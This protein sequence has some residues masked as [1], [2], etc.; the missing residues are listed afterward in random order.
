[1]AYLLVITNSTRDD[2]SWSNRVLARFVET[3][4]AEHPG[5]E[6]RERSTLSIP[7]LDL[8]SQR[9]GRVPAS[10][11]TP[12]QAAAFALTNELTAEVENA[13]AVVIATPMYNWGPP[14]SLKAWIDHIVN[15]RT[16]YQP[17]GMLDGLPVTAIIASGGFYSEGEMV[18]HD[19]LRPLLREVFGRIGITDLEFVNCDPTGPMDRGMV[20]PADPDSGFSRALAQVPAAA[21]R[22][23]RVDSLVS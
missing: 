19:N 11:H 6:V 3:F 16:F 5:I 21:A 4:T 14:S 12:E 13:V 10:Q 23:R 8:A 2:A 18:V 20:D 15:F 7:H 1:M 9:A 17:T 22:I